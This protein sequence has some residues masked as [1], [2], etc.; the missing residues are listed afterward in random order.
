MDSPYKKQKSFEQRQLETNTIFKKYDDYIPIIVDKDPECLLPDIDQQKFL[1]PYDALMKDF[2]EIIRKR[3]NILPSDSLFL[4]VNGKIPSSHRTIGSL[5][6]GNKDKDGFLY[7]VYS[8]TNL[9]NANESI[10]DRLN[11]LEKE[12]ED[13]KKELELAKNEIRLL[14]SKHDSN[15]ISKEIDLQK[16]S[17]PS[18]VQKIRRFLRRIFYILIIILIIYIC[19][20]VFYR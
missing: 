13:L 19:F 12:H 7:C 9:N 11:Q 3:I 16:E 8:S 10:F 17:S 4:F 1:L 15:E 2:V 6:E 20:K 14:K 5:Y 18:F